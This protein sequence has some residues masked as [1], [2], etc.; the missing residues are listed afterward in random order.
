V[1]KR[2]TAMCL[3]HAQKTADAFSN[4]G[5]ANNFVNETYEMA[6][7]V[8][9]SE[10]IASAVFRKRPSGQLALYAMKWIN[11]G[12]RDDQGIGDK[13][14][15]IG[16]FVSYADFM[17]FEQVREQLKKIETYNTTSKVAT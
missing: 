14:Y 9:C 4:S 10:T 8:N 5:R 1:K 15:V 3:Q 7:L 17:G 2:V 11:A 6:K 13:S 16:F 12:K